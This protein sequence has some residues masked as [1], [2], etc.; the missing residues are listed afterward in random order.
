M[1][2]LVLVVDDDDRVREVL[3]F[4]LEIAGHE[5]ET[6][7]DG[8]EALDRIEQLQ[9]GVIVLDLMMP[10]MDGRC[11]SAELARRGLRSEVSILLLSAG[12]GLEQASAVI[13]PDACLGKPFDLDTLLLE[14]DRLSRIHR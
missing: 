14:V 8:L 13:E 11:F 10:R 6:A 12:Y 4:A 7:A 9:P 2:R 5:V 1:S 3:V